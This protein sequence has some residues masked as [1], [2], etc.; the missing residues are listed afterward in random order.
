MG[1][2]GEQYATQ[3]QLRKLRGRTSDLNTPDVGA[4][5]RVTAWRLRRGCP[6]Q[7]DQGCA[8]PNG[9]DL[10][11]LEDWRECAETMPRGSKASARSSGDRPARAGS[12]TSGGTVN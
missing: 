12:S 1:E 2:E 9:Q 6:T 4:C 5:A 8:R 7:D 3:D 11:A 10:N